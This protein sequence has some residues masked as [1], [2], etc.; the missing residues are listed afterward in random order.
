M[1]GRAKSGSHARDRERS[2]DHISIKELT[3]VSPGDFG[4]QSLRSVRTSDMRRRGT[5]Y[6][7]VSV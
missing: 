6:G 1:E 7:N 2:I 4:R 3:D 5:V